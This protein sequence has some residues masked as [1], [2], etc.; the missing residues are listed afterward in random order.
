MPATSPSATSVISAL[1]PAL[2]GPAQVHAQQHLRPVLRLG[3]AGAGL[4]V[5]EAV[6]RIHLAREHALELEARD[7]A[8][9]P[10]HVLLDRA[11]HGLVRVGLGQ[12]EQFA[13]LVQA[14]A[15]AVEGADHCLELGAF[16]AQFLRALRLVPDG[17][18]FE[19]AQ[20]FGQA[21]G[22]ALVVKDTP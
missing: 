7:L 4:D 22:A 10:V 11:H 20:D 18:V 9:D 2:V 13:G 5:E 17:G 14:D 16:A 12:L 8:F 15:Q 1:K 6:V 19:L 3:A 21:L